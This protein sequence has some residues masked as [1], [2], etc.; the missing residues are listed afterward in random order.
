MPKARI[1][2][3][4]KGIENSFT[5]NEARANVYAFAQKQLKIVANA[6]Y[7]LV[8]S[9]PHESQSI[10][11]LHVDHFV[12]HSKRI[13]HETPKV[14]LY[15]AKVVNRTGSSYQRGGEASSR[16]QE[17]IDRIWND[18][19]LAFVIAL[20][21]HRAL[22]LKGEQVRQ[23]LS[24][25]RISGFTGSSIVALVGAIHKAEVFALNGVESIAEN[26]YRYLL[27]KSH[28]IRKLTS[29][30]RSLL[31]WRRVATIYMAGT[32]DH[33]QLKQIRTLIYYCHQAL[34]DESQFLEQNAEVTDID[35]L[36]QR[37]QYT[38]DEKA[39]TRLRQTM[40]N[41]YQAAITMRYCLVQSCSPLMSAL[42]LSSIERLDRMLT[43]AH[44][45]RAQKTQHT[46]SDTHTKVAIAIRDAT[47]GTRFQCQYEHAVGQSAYAIDVLMKPM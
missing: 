13:L 33:T 16:I 40:S 30:E 24:R 6:A 27:Q 1:A 19:A 34:E 15:H 10:N 3:S 4:L 43:L 22:E 21:Q 47:D 2:L 8:R 31:L 32:A 38:P 26:C 29:R 17:R 42:G 41:I 37:T 5:S 36:Q 25:L 18:A 23:V 14:C 44:N 46:S 7:A 45:L 28:I 35:K 9:D 20:S 12:T 39:L 11:S